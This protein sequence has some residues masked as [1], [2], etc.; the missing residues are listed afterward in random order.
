MLEENI[1]NCAIHINCFWEPF[2]NRCVFYNHKL[3][4]VFSEKGSKA[5]ANLRGFFM[6]NRCWSK[7][8]QRLEA[9]PRK[10]GGDQQ[11]PKRPTKAE[12]TNKSR[13]DQQR[14]KSH[15][16]KELPDVAASAIGWGDSKARSMCT[17]DTT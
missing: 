11:R 9:R 8:Q 4:V 7:D 5:S 15:R 6:C 16:R 3:V 10:A 1:E 2:F 14:P 17:M 13:K 12:K